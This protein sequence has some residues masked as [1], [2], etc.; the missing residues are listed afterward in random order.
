MLGLHLL[1][2]LLSAEAAQAER[3]LT[4]KYVVE[5]AHALD[6]QE[7]LIEGWMSKCWQLSCSLYASADEVKKGWPY[8][9]SI[10]ASS[11]FDPLLRKRTPGRVTIRARFNN[12]CVTNPVS[13]TIAV[14]ADR[15]NTLEPL[16]IVR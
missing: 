3:P 8:A 15:P 14:C 13:R 2:A 10:G 6:G 12:R 4:V 11:R 7:I 1:I 5:N 16:A 9:L